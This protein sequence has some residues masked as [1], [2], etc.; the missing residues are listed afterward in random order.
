MRSF[1]CAM[2]PCLRV[3]LVVCFLVVASPAWA[4]I[5]DVT[6][7]SGVRAW[8][9]EDH[10]LPL[11]TV[12]FSFEGGAAIDPDGKEGLSTLLA[13]LLDEGAGDL[14]SRSFQNA[15][16]ERSISLGFSADEDRL[17]GVLRTLTRESDNAFALL[18]LALHE[19]RFDNEALERMRDALVTQR[20]YNLSDPN[21][22]ASSGFEQVAMAGHPYG[23]AAEGTIETLKAIRRDDL[24]AAV[25]QHLVRNRLTVAVVGDMTPDALSVMLD[26]VFGDL[27]VGAES[28]GIP[29]LQVGGAGELVLI[30]RDQPQTVLL[31][32][33]PGLRRDDPDWFAALTMS[34]VLGGGF[35]SRL[36]SEIRVKRGLTYGIS[37]ALVPYAA[38]GVFYTLASSDNAKVAELLE[39]LRGQ[40]KM[41]AMD[42][43]TDTELSEAKTYLTGSFALRFS[44]SA[45][46]A[47]V[48]LEVQ[49]LGLS[50]RYL[51][52]RA[53]LINAVTR[54]DIARVAEKMLRPEALT[55]IAVGAPDGLTPTRTLTITP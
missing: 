12:S 6:S 40:I 53:N 23:R 32:G 44:S 28:L 8:L 20:Q 45:R 1:R 46:I 3:L 5:H 33:L 14:D 7:R 41:L 26:Q 16:A 10:T 49:R 19:P 22:L 47:D 29:P 42:G 13:S 25:P 51:S 2:I 31:A 27:P 15:L 39:A 34:Y 55:L 30:P 37:S 21:W 18:R 24:V 43:V 11:V 52:D 9:V 36:M 4:Q 17:S 50:P 38:G 35:Q 54:T 48:L